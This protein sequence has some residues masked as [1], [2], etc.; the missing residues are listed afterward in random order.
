MQL[1]LGKSLTKRKAI[2]PAAGPPVL[3]PGLEI[4]DEEGAFLLDEEGSPL[5][6]EV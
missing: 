3:P 6:Q 2:G 5:E 1:G 4:L